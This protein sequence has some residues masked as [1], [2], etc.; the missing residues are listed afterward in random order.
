MNLFDIYMEAASKPL[1]K[2]TKIKDIQNFEKQH[3]V[4]VVIENEYNLKILLDLFLQSNNEKAFSFAS[5]YNTFPIYVSPK[6]GGW[7]D[8]P[9]RNAYYVGLKDYKNYIQSL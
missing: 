5:K 1:P 8:N 9:N 2:I 6:D 3:Y 4:F 7:T